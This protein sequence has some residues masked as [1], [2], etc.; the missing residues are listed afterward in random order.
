MV[1]LFNI[2]G[3]IAIFMILTNII[4]I[5]IGEDLIIYFGLYSKYPKLA[6]YIQFQLTLRKYLLRFYIV[7][8][9][10]KGGYVFVKIKNFCFTLSKN[11]PEEKIEVRMM[12]L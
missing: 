2:C 10:E 5:L 8:L 1:I 6:K 4:L 7:K 12:E 11:P 9:C 3:Y